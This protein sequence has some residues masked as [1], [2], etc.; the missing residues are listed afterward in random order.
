MAAS[1]GDTAADNFTKAS[2]LKELM[3]TGSPFME[4]ASSTVTHMDEKWKYPLDETT[5]N[6]ATPARP[7]M[8]SP[9]TL[10]NERYMQRRG[11]WQKKKSEEFA[12]VI[13]FHAYYLLPFPTEITTIVTVLNHRVPKSPDSR[14]PVQISFSEPYNHSS[15]VDEASMISTPQAQH[16]PRGPL[17]SPSA[18]P[19]LKVLHQHARLDPP[20]DFTLTK[21]VMES[22][23]TTKLI[24]VMRER[25]KSKPS[26]FRGMFPSRS[27]YARDGYYTLADIQEA[28]TN[29]GFRNATSE[30]LLQALGI[31]SC[32][33]YVHLGDIMQALT[34]ESMG[35]S[36]DLA[37]WQHAQWRTKQLAHPHKAMERHEGSTSPVISKLDME[38]TASKA[39]QDAQASREWWTSRSHVPDN[40]TKASPRRTFTAE[41]AFEALS[42]KVNTSSSVRPLFVTADENKSGA[43]ELGDLMSLVS[44]MGMPMAHEE[45][46]RLMSMFDADKNGKIEYGE[47]NDKL[48]D[49]SWPDYQNELAMSSARSEL[50]ALCSNDEGAQ[51]LHIANRPELSGDLDVVSAQLKKLHPRH[52]FKIILDS[53]ESR[54][55]TM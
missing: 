53:L 34:S 5:R 50:Y 1:G 33:D 26:L 18:Y 25:V 38:Q 48:L 55:G 9:S 22:D 24:K 27:E 44:K 39:F 46:V 54:F 31:S 47:W 43:I 14:N 10:R 23:S 7:G 16:S 20:L 4:D 51:K 52:V 8:P 19:Q 36:L 2:A 30:A 15:N 32:V 3:T 29:L 37:D 45:I 21:E 40:L 41:E 6:R 49:W 12:Y 13:L 42:Q 17:R 35:E 28:I 11:R